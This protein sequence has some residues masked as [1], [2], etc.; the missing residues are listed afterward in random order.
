MLNIDIL[1]YW[2]C[3]IHH[4]VSLAENE[5][6]RLIDA[7]RR[8]EDVKTLGEDVVVDDSGVER[9]ETHQRDQ[10]AT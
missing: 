6:V 5:L 9:E 7:P 1:P 2:I 10:V 8:A 3:R 4:V